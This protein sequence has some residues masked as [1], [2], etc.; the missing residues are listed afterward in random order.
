MTNQNQRNSFIF[1]RSFF[2]T[3]EDLDDKQQL[4]IYRA[5]S[6]YSLNDKLIELTG[7]SKTIFRLIEPQ[8]LANK[9]RFI[10]GTKGAEH[11]KKGGRP[12]T[13]KKPQDNPKETPDLT[14]NK[15]NN[16][17]PN[18]ELES[19]SESQFESFWQS[20]KEIHTSK[21]S[22]EDAKKSFL[23]SLK[24]STFEEIEQGLKNYMDH[25]H[26]KNSYTK[27]VVVWLNKEGW[28]DEYSTAKEEP[29]S[30]FAKWKEGR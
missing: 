21:G 18:S 5:I 6:E 22:K 30:D 8:L 20:Y 25:C 7:L 15:N 3:L 1:Y 10:N 4:E 19:Q 17:N 9:K 26:S 23:K 14:P 2:E 24:K 11:G 29:K 16:L 12:K 27:Q 28:K 13:P